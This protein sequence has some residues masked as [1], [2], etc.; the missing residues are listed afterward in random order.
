ME[1]GLMQKQNGKYEE[2]IKTFKKA[3]K[4]YYKKKK[5]YNYLK[6]KRELA[7][8]VWAKSA[9]IDTSNVTISRLPKTVNTKNSELGLT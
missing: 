6:A 5:S 8:T 4:K 2:A 1:C 9:R 7:S 3:K